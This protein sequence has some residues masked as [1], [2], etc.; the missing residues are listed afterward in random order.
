[1]SKFITKETFRKSMPLDTPYS[2]SVRFRFLED[3]VGS[4]SAASSSSSEGDSVSEFA[5]SVA[6]TIS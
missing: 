4:V 1:M 6:S 5:V 2:G 3:L